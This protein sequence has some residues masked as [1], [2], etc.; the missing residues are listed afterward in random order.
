MF[1]TF[2]PGFG[3]PV[4]ELAHL[5]AEAGIRLVEL[6]ES[7]DLLAA[8]GNRVSLAVG[9]ACA[10][11]GVRFVT[12]GRATLGLSLLFGASIALAFGL[13]ASRANEDAPPSLL[14]LDVGHGD[15]VLVRSGPEAWLVD[16]GPRLASFDAGRRLVLPALRAEGVRVLNALVLTH[17][18][19]DH[20]GGA[21]SV[22][23]GVRVTE[24]WMSQATLG[25]PATQRVR[26]EAA[27]LGIPI[28]LVAKGDT[29]RTSGL[30]I[31]MLWP[32]SGSLPRSSNSASL[33]LR[34]R[35]GQLCAML[36]GDVPARVERALAPEMIRC[37]I[38]KLSHHGSATST[39]PAWLKALA[40]RIAV[41]S[42]GRRSRFPLPHPDVR[43]RV[44]EARTRLWETS[45]HGAIRIELG[46]GQ[47][48]VRPFL[49]VPLAR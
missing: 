39:A 24:L 32:P 22:L 42:A 10:G 30:H 37:E 41:V 15:A 8:A 4:V 13:T 12:L 27:R 46:G 48:E 23:R 17:P 25:A 38:L 45:R 2:A 1:G 18:D 6:L 14:F 9:L 40:P 3:V 31:D 26:R 11:F 7:P 43:R 29:W 36:P 5:V 47:A 20:I 19:R 16:A 44:L 28:R 34:I 33:V 21:E 35:A 49:P